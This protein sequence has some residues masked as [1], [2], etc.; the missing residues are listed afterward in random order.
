MSD[1]ES[2]QNVIDSYR[3]R[4][5]VAKKAPLIFGIAALLLIVG[6]GF[7]I[8]WLA[9]AEP[10]SLGLRPTET[11]TPTLTYTSTS[12]ATST[13]TEIPTETNTPEPT[14]TPEPTL[15]PTA[16]SPF[17]Y[18]VSQGDSLD[19][20]ARRFG[21]DLLTIL[22]LNPTLNPNLIFVGQQI[23]IPAPDTQLPTKT[24]VPLTCR[25]KQE[26]IVKSGDDLSMIAILFYS[27]V[28]AIVK[29]NNLTNP[30]NIS[31]GDKLIIPCGIATPQATWTPAPEGVT[32]GAIMTLTPTYTLTP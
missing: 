23:L 32:P 20:I 19:E 3:K 17:I 13:P 6:A 24:P 16:A 15:T 12:T 18:T 21:V 8:F 4:Q 25:G 31:A 29:E 7:I 5:V 14:D 28:D 27:T 9:G 10:P 26:Y 22:E 1:K 2:A 30:N 11:L